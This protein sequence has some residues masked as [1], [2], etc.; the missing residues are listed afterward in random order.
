MRFY[1]DHS[2]VNEMTKT[3]LSFDRKVSAIKNTRIKI[4]MYKRKGYK[5]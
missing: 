4:C 1:R 2:K 3:V 5:K